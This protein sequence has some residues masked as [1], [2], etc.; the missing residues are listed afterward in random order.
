MEEEEGGGGGD[1]TGKMNCD[2]YFGLVEVVLGWSA[3]ADV[4]SVEGD[5]NPKA[6]PS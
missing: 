2:C 1:G 5:G 3:A 6:T 4:E